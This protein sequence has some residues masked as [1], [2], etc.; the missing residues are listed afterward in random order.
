M[1]AQNS[2][3]I[4]TLLDAEQKAAQIVQKA[5]EFRTKR[6]REA[7]DEARKEIDA[8]KAQKEA[9]FKAFE[10]EHSQGNKAAEEVAN[11][12][13][14]VKIVEIKAAGKK[15]QAVVVKDLLAAVLNA[16]PVAPTK[17]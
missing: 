13:A 12:E 14:D 11:K 1:S 5:R 15:S 3:G 17:A 7:R 16:N 6:V 10:A 9:E 4:Q 2:Q 8:Y